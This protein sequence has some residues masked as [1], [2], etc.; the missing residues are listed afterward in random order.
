[1]G[2]W[3][4]EFTDS[5]RVAHLGTIAA[6]GRA[7][8]VPVC[9]APVATEFVIAIDGKPKRVGKLARIANIERDP[10]CSLLWDRYDDDWTQ[11]AW[12]RADGGAHV[13][14]RGAEMPE[15]LA[16]LRS[17]YEQY[18]EMQLEEM[19]LIVFRASRTVSW[20][21]SGEH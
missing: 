20:R 17:R 4:T 3:E 9:F 18:E 19:P 10:R 21:W 12:V 2:L 16:A 15:A 8:I 5:C 11:L 13:V 7:H 6:D 1:M 14:Q